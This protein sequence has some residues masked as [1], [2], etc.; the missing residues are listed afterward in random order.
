VEFS[1]E[2]GRWWDALSADE[3]DSIATGVRLLEAHGP[4]LDYPHSSKVVTSRH[5]RMCELRVQHDGR[6]YRVFYCFDPRRAAM[7]LIG[8][9]KTGDNRFYETMVPWADA[10]YDQHLKELANEAEKKETG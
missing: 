3:Q 10:I 5:S 2:F 1:D 6:P 9:D 8:G 4:T 7:L